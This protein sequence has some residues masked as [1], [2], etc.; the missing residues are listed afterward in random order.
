M[1]KVDLSKYVCKFILDRLILDG[2]FISI[3]VESILKANNLITEEEEVRLVSRKTGVNLLPSYQKGYGR[4]ENVN[5][6]KEKARSFTYYNLIFPTNLR[7]IFIIC[8]IPSHIIAK[9]EGKLTYK[10][11]VN[12]CSSLD[13]EVGLWLH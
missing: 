11:C 5:L 2:R 6:F 3:S 8:K 12:L 13:K 10:E 9:T 7:D 1:L 4:F